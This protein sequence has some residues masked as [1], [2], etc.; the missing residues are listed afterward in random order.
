ME[1]IFDRARKFLLYFYEKLEGPIL[2]AEIN[3]ICE[4]G[5]SL[6]HLICKN[7]KQLKAPQNKE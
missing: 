3:K 1:D 2:N 7:S 6:I 5:T 4:P